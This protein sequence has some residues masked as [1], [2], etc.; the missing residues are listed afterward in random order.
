MQP[1]SNWARTIAVPTQWACGAAG[2][3]LPWHGRGRRFDPDQVHHHPNL[4]PAVYILQSES[5]GRF[6][7]GCAEQ[8]LM[9]LAE[10]QRGQTASTRGRGPWILV[11][12]ERFDTLSQARKR[13]RQ[14]KSWK[15]HR[16]IQ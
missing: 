3:A 12:Q 14:L 2:S 4:M 11:Y 7:I 8:P 13:E 1:S 15:S 6:Y 16:S 10:H 9:R 5:S